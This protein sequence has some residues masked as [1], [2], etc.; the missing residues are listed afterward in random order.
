MQNGVIKKEQCGQSL[1]LRR[2]RHIAIDGQACQERVHRRFTQVQ[3][4]LLSVEQ[5]EPPDPRHVSLFG[6]AGE[7]HG[8]SR[9]ADAVEKSGRRVAAATVELLVARGT[10]GESLEGVRK[11]TLRYPPAVSHTNR[12]AGPARHSP[13]D[14]SRPATMS[15]RAPPKSASRFSPMPLQRTR[16]AGE[17][18]LAALTERVRRRHARLRE[19]ISFRRRENTGIAITAS[20]RSITSSGPPSRRWRSDRGLARVPTE[21]VPVP[22]SAPQ[23]KGQ[24][25]TASHSEPVPRTTPHGLPGPS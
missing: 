5:N 4:V 23:Q 11:Y 8:S 19:R 12:P 14:G 7:M 2:C 20:L 3:G 13:A 25:P 6:A 10:H 18:G 15:S 24:A 22:V 21:Q 16:A 9:H 1:I 17:A